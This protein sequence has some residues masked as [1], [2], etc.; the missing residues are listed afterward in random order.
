MG[1]KLD[2]ARQI[3][4]CIKLR[5]LD[6]FLTVAQRGS[7]AKAAAQLGVSQ[8]A[9]SAVI[10]DLERTLGVPLFDR[11]TR[12]VK[13]TMYARAMMDCSVAAFDE[14]K[15]GIRTLENLADPEAG[16][17]WIGCIESISALMLPPILQQF[18]QRYPRVVV[19]VLRLSSPTP[20]FRDLCERNLDLVLGR[21]AKEP[22]KDFE[23]ASQPLF[24]YRAVIAAGA[25]SRWAR[26]RKVDLADLVDEPWVL[27]PPEC[28]MHTA[29]K[30]AFRAR[31]LKSPRVALMTHSIP[32]RMSLV[33]SG[34]YITVFPD[35]IR[36][37]NGYRH[38]IRILPI[39]LPASPMPLSIIT[40]K[41]RTLNPVAQRFIEHL[42]SYVAE[43]SADLVGAEATLSASPA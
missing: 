15:Q 27:T 19:H 25:H 2:S 13:P 29:I 31:G 7:M 41:N 37:L 22:A 35:S 6:V 34:P 5:D 36:S 32:L 9:V 17:L 23:L 30:E 4:R 21:M 26:R 12:G 43:Q 3:G 28:R 42:R 1:G 40:L 24:D 8:P 18:M 33:A 38:A 14:L 16:E 20:E 39:D 11:N 10:A